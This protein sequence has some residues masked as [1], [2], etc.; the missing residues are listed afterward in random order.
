[1]KGGRARFLPEPVSLKLPE[2][3][4]KWLLAARSREN[5]RRY[6]PVDRGI[7]VA[8]ESTLRSV[9]CPHLLRA[10][11]RVRIPRR[12][13]QGIHDGVICRQQRCEIDPPGGLP[14]RLL[15]LA[16]VRF[17]LLTADASSCRRATACGYRQ[18][19]MSHICAVPVSMASVSWSASGG[20]S[21][22]SILPIQN[23]R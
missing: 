14:A 18:V 8:T 10:C 20:A 9:P 6:M 16:P 12:Q 2:Q 4:S 22:G 13:A 21:P 15:L 7:G 3:Y 1:M 17:V 23:T 5:P 19:R 11:L